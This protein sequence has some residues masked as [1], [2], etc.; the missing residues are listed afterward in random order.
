MKVVV[1]V[2][3]VAELDDEF[4]LREDGLDVD[5][6][7]VEWTL[8]EWDGFAVEEA[9]SLVEEHGGEVV[10]VSLGDE[11]AEEPIRQCLAKGAERGIRIWDDGLD[12]VDALGAAV[13]LAAA[14]EREEPDLVL[15]GVQSSDGASGATGTA[16]AGRLGLPHVAVVRRLEYDSGTGAATVH[17]ELEGG[18]I[19]VAKVSTPA[20][21]TIQSG[22][23]EPRYA[24]LRAI[25]QADQKPLETLSLGDLDLDHEL[26]KSATGARRRHASVPAKGEGAEMIEGS[27]EDVATRVAEIV[28][29]ALAA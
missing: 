11:G 15:F 19:E 13:P 27:P 22:I 26:V 23:N 29:E 14:I 16:V 12:A 20:L 3:R 1:A 4:E 17:R 18:L 7:F 28:K 25:K 10:V 2:K 5:E 8:N 21:L 24:T 9:L 6:D